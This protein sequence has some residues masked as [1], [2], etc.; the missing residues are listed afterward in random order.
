MFFSWQIFCLLNNRK[1]GPD[2]GIKALLT[3][4]VFDPFCSGPGALFDELTYSDE[5][6]LWHSIKEDERV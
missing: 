3:W 2:S 4:P 5:L 1:S 6:G